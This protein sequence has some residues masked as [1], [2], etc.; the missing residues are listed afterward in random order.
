MALTPNLHI[1]SGTSQ[2]SRA[3]DNGS[4]YCNMLI[5]RLKIKPA[6]RRLRN[7]AVTRF[8]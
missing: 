6:R 4:V 7:V 2:V 5:I 3:T 8:Q 1:S